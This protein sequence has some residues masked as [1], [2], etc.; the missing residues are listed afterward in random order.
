MTCR[1]WQQH[2]HTQ[3]DTELLDFH[4][5]SIGGSALSLVHTVNALQAELHSSYCNLLTSGL[6][7]L[8]ALHPSAA[9][10]V[11]E[12]VAEGDFVISANRWSLTEDYILIVQSV[13]T[14][15]SLSLTSK[16]STMHYRSQI[17]HGQ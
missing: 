8:I 15:P 9:T 13:S 3:L 7:K 2:M 12:L 5:I 17:N 4:G 10:L 6:K 14:Y 11:I 16:F 1:S